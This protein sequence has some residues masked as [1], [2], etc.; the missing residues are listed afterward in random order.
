MLTGQPPFPEGSISERL[1]KHQ[2]ATPESIFKLRPDTP[3]SLVDICEQMMAK[4]PDDRFQSAGD[5]A[6]R[7]TEWLGERG[8]KLGGGHIEGRSEESGVGSG[9]FTRF[10][11]TSQTPFPS[12]GSSG[13][14]ASSETISAADRDTAKLDDKG[15]DVGEEIGLA[16]LDE[17][18][19]AV[20][21]GSGQK[22]KKSLTDSGP[23][24]DVP[25]DLPVSIPDTSKSLVEE[26]FHDPQAE[27]IRRKV[28]QRAQYNP[29]KPP[30]Y[31]PP[32]RGNP[33]GL[34]IGIGVAVV[35]VVGIVL[36]MI[37]S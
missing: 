17:D 5:V 2:T 8:R 31:V 25:S 16:P 36:Y 33:I 30:G 11:L 9:I 27:A 19:E 35:A 15:S 7:L 13:S 6:V 1:L 32:K 3:P 21:G 22:L 23:Q 4:K 26:E 12:A 10:A 28:A 37:L 29:L 24:L 20:L 18:Q 34:W 14:P